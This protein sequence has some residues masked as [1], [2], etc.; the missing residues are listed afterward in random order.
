MRGVLRTAGK[1][2]EPP[3]P[4]SWILVGQASKPEVPSY[5]PGTL[6]RAGWRARLGATAA[7][8]GP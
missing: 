3:D 8:R 2:T 4:G 1:G 7:N 5:F 6:G